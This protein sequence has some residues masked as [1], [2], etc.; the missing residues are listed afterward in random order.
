VTQRDRASC[1]P[2][3]SSTDDRTPAA[4]DVRVAATCS[5]ACS[6]PAPISSL[7]RAVDRDVDDPGDR[8][9]VRTTD[10]PACALVLVVLAALPRA[11]RPGAWATRA[12]ATR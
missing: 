2:P 3:P 9:E 10:A 4:A 12:E 11:R 7:L 1:S 8:L 5:T 6:T